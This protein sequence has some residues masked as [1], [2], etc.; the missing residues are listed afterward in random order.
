MLSSSDDDALT[1]NTIEIKLLEAKLRKAKSAKK[2]QLYQDDGAQPPA[3]PR[4]A[5]QVGRTVATKEEAQ[6]LV[7]FCSLLSFS[8]LPTE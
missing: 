6:T 8:H 7:R 5:L 4:V 1:P 3:P 2:R